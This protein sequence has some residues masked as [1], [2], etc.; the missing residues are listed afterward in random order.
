MSEIVVKTIL[1][2]RNGRTTWRVLS[3]LSIPAAVVAFV[4][5]R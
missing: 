1:D 5:A 3:L 4:A 2:L